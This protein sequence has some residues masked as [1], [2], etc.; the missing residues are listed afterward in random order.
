VIGMGHGTFGAEGEAR[1]QQRCC[2]QPRQR[3]IPRQIDAAHPHFAQD[4]A[5]RALEIIGAIAALAVVGIAEQEHAQP[6]PSS[7]RA[8]PHELDCGEQLVK[9]IGYLDEHCRGAHQGQRRPGA[10]D[11]RLDDDEQDRDDA[12]RYI[13]APVQQIKVESVGPQP[14]EA[15]LAGLG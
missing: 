3:E 8:S 15:A 4:R 2:E 11:D 7:L 5:G 9:R 10:D 12:Q 13:A 14:R 1:E 6:R